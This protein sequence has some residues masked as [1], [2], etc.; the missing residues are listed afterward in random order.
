MLRQLE[1]Q[2]AMLQN[3]VRFI[4]LVVDNRLKVAKRK[5]AELIAELGRL[6]FEQFANQ[7][8]DAEGDEAEEGSEPAAGGYDYLLSMPLWS[9]TLERVNALVKDRDA[10]VVEAEALRNTQPTDIWLRDLEALEE[11]LLK[12]TAPAQSVAGK[13]SKKSAPEKKA[14]S[15]DC[16]LPYPVARTI[17]PKVSRRAPAQAK[18][19][20]SKAQSKTQK[21]KGE[22]SHGS[23]DDKPRPVEQKASVATMSLQDGDESESDFEL[24]LTDR[25]AKRMVISGEVISLDSDDESNKPKEK[26]KPKR[27]RAPRTAVTQAS[28]AGNSPETKTPVPKR[29][30]PAARLRK[31]PVVSLSSDSSDEEESG[32]NADVVQRVAPREQRTRRRVATVSYIVSSDDNDNEG[33]KDAEIED[34]DFE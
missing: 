13:K 3:K 6:G 28:A 29:T 11:V 26:V 20:G 10:K 33:D 1:R 27:Q 8:N 5:K 25:L 12:P 21:A 2:V 34:S 16:R 17:A 32:S 30:K 23:D 15:E 31:K 24:S 14:P 9:L 22:G 18:P 4:M 19:R 7:K